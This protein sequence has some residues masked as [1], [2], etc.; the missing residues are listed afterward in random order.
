MTDTDMITLIATSFLARVPALLLA[1]M[2]IDE[3]IIE[4]KRIDDQLLMDMYNALHNPQNA[5]YSA[6]HEAI[7]S[8]T[9]DVYQQLKEQDNKAATNVRYDLFLEL[10]DDHSHRAY[11]LFVEENM[12]AFLVE[13]KWQRASGLSK[14]EHKQFDEWLQ[15]KYTTKGVM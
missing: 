1:G 7:S 3:A 4:A 8:L 9:N 15:A 2:T 10:S 6:H 11:T 14:N 5:Y 12:K 13:M